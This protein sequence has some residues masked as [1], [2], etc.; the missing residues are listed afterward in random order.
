MTREAKRGREKK[1]KKRQERKVK[2]EEE[3]IA[4]PQPG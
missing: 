1:K 3:G 4:L 2:K